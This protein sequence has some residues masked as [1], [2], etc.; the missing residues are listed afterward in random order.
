M[1]TTC[2][3]WSRAEY[4]V[5]T[6]DKELAWPIAENQQLCQPG[7]LAG[8]QSA[9]GLAQQAGGSVPGCS[10]WLGAFQA[11]QIH[12]RGL[13]RLYRAQGLGHSEDP[14]PQEGTWI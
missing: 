14:P 2:R 3:L 5:I 12:A 10:R 4:L 6:E 11:G 13:A 9:P 7:T 8:S 1:K